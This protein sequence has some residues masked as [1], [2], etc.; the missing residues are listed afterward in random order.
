MPCP[1]FWERCGLNAPVPS[2][3]QPPGQPMLLSNQTSGKSTPLVPAP[4]TA[5]G[6]ILR[7]SVP[8]WVLPAFMGLAAFDTAAAALNPGAALAATGAAAALGAAGLATQRLLLPRL[9]KLPSSGLAVSG[10]GGASWGVG[11]LEGQGGSARHGGA[12][13]GGRGDSAL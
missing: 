2:P 13:E 9:R 8:G 5:D 7:S 4:P 10:C 11:I 3:T 6:S 1:L 12:G